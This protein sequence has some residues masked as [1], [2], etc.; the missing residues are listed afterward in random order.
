ME[1]VTSKSTFDLCTP[2]ET[3]PGCLAAGWGS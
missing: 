1:I 3:K 2:L